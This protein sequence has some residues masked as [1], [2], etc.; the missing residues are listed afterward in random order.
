MR[1]GFALLYVIA[2]LLGV[3]AVA[4]A[5][6]SIAGVVRDDSGAVLPGV[7]VE[8]ASP[9]WS[10]KTRSVVTD[11][12]GQYKIVDLRPGTYSVTFTLPGFSTIKREGI[13]LNGSFTA[14]VNADLKVGAVQ[15]TITVSG[16]P[17]I[18]DVQSTKRE[19]VLDHTVI[20]AVPTGRL[21]QQLGVLITG[22]SNGQGLSQTGTGGPQDVGGTSGNPVTLLVAHG[23]RAF[24][25]RI[26][27]DGLS[28]NLAAGVN[29][30][31]YTPNMGATQEVAIDIS[32][33]SAESAEGGV[34]INLIPKDGG[35][36]YSGSIF[37]DFANGSM[38]DSNI[39]DDLRKRG[40]TTPN[41]L[42]L[43]TSFNPAFGGPITRDKLWFYSS[44]RMQNAR[45]WVGGMFYD[46]T[47]NDPTVFT[48]N[49]D[50]AHRVSNDGLWNSAEARLTWQ[51]TP[52]NKFA[53]AF[54]KEHQCKCPS[55][56]RATTSPGLDGRWGWPHHMVTATWTSPV[57]S[58]VLLEGGFFQQ[59]NRWGFFRL[60]GTN[61]DLPGILEQS[62]NI[63]Y[64][65]RPNGYSDKLQHDM[66]YR[67]ALSY[68]TGA[69]AVK[70]G[71]SN[72]TG[73]LD[74]LWSV[75][76]NK[77]VYY[78]FNNGIPNQIT[79]WATPFHDG[80]KLDSELG[81]FA[82]DRWTINHLTLSGGVRFDRYKSHFPALTFGPVQLAPTRSF[83]I[84]D[85]PNANW[86]DITPRMGAAFDVF[87]NGKTALKVGLNKYVVG[88]DGP[89]FQSA[90]NV[91][92]NV[93]T[94]TVRGWTDSNSNF[95][96]DCDL[97]NPALNGECGAMQNPNF[98][99]STIGT[100]YDPK[101]LSG[102]GVRTYDWEFSADVQ[103]Q[104]VPRVAV[105]VGY[106]RRW[107][108]NL[109]VTDDRSLSAADFDQFSIIAP[110]DSRLQ[111][112]GGYPITGLY[113]LNPRRFGVPADLFVTLAS[114]YGKQIEHWNGVDVSVNAR[115]QGGLVLQGGVS[116]GRTSTDNCAVV[117]KL[118]E[119]I[120]TINTA[121]PYGYCHVNT[122]FL[123][124]VKGLASYTVAR[125]GIQLSGALQSVPGPQVIAT[126]NAP[127]SAVQP[128]LG[129]VL[130]GN[131]ANVGVNLV[132]PGSW[133]GDRMNQ[134]DLRVGKLL[135]ISHAK[136]VV[137][138]DLYNALN[139]N[140]VLTESLAFGNFRQPQVVL[141]PRF[142]KFSWQFDF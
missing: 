69:H 142:V 87:G 79:Q 57:T 23:S 63:G 48:L 103:H 21:P 34:R 86:K 77:N 4:H 89:A 60:K 18:V 2:L 93:V 112:G 24:D 29:N 72:A 132:A 75:N 129:R 124:H 10:A 141:V 94:T 121:T 20:D 116:S 62:T 70:V 119:V 109:A 25:Q 33:V 140:A 3:P 110:S 41:E 95:I 135:T 97:T 40:F 127:N 130:S 133:Y 26:T 53:L 81:V 107:Y 19:A 74:S 32:G 76:G 50:P 82:Q 106:F 139:S 85:I 51:A 52:K 102:W 118:P 84:P 59:S 105:D 138:V 125:F 108:G 6:A 35:N 17:P 55:A 38:S 16:E 11:G 80:W 30:T 45:N 46:S 49:Q 14:T 12:T 99:K 58:R 123:T 54:A 126:F 98:G 128:A 31:L 91:F 117:T 61:P 15:E 7:T 122:P 13:E 28:I 137:S 37:A 67:A 115:L 92:A 136:S 83:S 36:R 68:I 111:N 101:L 96:P 1:R 8:A 134:L 9:A 90:T 78:R 66:R 73:D 39:T 104:V 47:W 56:I 5:Q 113:N 131:Q 120:A 71:F 88:Q 43:V 44:Y 65:L 100:T 42:R 27:I 114:N 64:K 22:V